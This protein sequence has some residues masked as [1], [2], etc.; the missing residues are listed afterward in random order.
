MVLQK[1]FASLKY[2][3]KTM[4]TNKIPHFFID[5]KDD[6]KKIKD[7]RLLIYVTWDDCAFD[8]LVFLDLCEHYC[9]GEDGLQLSGSPLASLSP[10]S[11]HRWPHLTPSL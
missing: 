7:C 4:K 11:S 8:F 10:A 2:K 6:L 3:Q 5:I 9:G 1:E